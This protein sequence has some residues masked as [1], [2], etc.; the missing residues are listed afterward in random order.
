MQVLP[1][2]EQQR[3]GMNEGVKVGMYG[4]AAL[5]VLG[6]AFFV[7]RKLLSAQLPKVQKVCDHLHTFER[8]PPHAGCACFHMLCD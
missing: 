5:V 8:S 3:T 2:V 6:G 7:G 4:I 1:Q